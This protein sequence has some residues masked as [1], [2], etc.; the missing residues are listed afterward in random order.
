MDLSNLYQSEAF[1]QM[2]NETPEPTKSAP[3]IEMPKVT[4]K[5]FREEQRTVWARGKYEKVTEEIN[6]YRIDRLADYLLYKA[7]V[8]E[9]GG[10]MEEA[11]AKR[12]ARRTTEL[13]NEKERSLKSGDLVIRKHNAKTFQKILRKAAAKAEYKNRNKT[14]RTEYPK[15]LST[16]QKVNKI[17]K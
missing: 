6:W 15:G 17:E 7:D 12:K 14:Y 16:Y 3:K 10:T 4:E 1:K 2:M 5:D 13:Q 8:E 9:R 11:S